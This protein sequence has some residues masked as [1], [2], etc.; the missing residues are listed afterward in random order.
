MGRFLLASAILL[1]G[2][3]SPSGPQMAPLVELRSSIPV[4]ALWAAHVGKVEDAILFPALVGDGLVR[5]ACTAASCR[6]DRGTSRTFLAW[7]R[8][9]SISWS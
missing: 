1:A 9:R 5:A 3:S 2:C 8:A 7:A 4:R 6:G